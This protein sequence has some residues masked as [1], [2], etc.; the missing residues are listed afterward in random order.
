M[1]FCENC[2]IDTNQNDVE[3]EEGEFDVSTF[4]SEHNG[5]NFP[6]VRNMG[7]E[8]DQRTPNQMPMP[9]NYQTPSS[10]H[11]NLPHGGYGKGQKP[12]HSEGKMMNSNAFMSAPNSNNMSGYNM[13]YQSMPGY[14]QFPMHGQY[15]NSQNMPNQNM[16]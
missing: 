15:P 3:D 10:N 4:N 9:H 7:M 16:N 5:Y 8:F 6:E 2:Y 12:L 14:V 13:G 11:Q 1:K